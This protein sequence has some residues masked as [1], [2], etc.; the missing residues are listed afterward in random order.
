MKNFSRIIG[1]AL[2][3]FMAVM[4]LVAFAHAEDVALNAQIQSVAQALDKNGAPYVRVIIEEQKKLSGVNYK[5]GVPVMFFGTLVEQGKAFKAGDTLKAI[6]A[7]RE[8]QGRT[9]YTVIQ[10]M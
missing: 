3:G 2:V 10:L 4:F 8:Y 6:C 5:V 1:T 9:S 7:K